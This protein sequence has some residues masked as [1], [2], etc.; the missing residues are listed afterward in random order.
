MKLRGNRNQC[1]TCNLYF[2][3][4]WAF[5]KHRTGTHGVDRRCRTVDEMLSKGMV[6]M[7]S[8]FWGGEKME[9]NFD[10]K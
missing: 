5:D 4:N 9:R 7:N 3:S 1:P 6:L 8:G 2:N 10:E